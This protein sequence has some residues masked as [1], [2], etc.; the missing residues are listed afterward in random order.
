MALGFTVRVYGEIKEEPLYIPDST[1]NLPGISATYSSPPN[2]NF[3]TTDPTFYPIADPGAVMIGG[4]SCYG[5]VALPASGL[6]VHGKKY[7]VQ[8]TIAQ[9]NTLRG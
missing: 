2:F 5:V 6:N 3:P 9:L 7:I 1:G 8:Q 4:V